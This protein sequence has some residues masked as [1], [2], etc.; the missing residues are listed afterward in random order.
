[1]LFSIRLFYTSVS[2]LLS[3]TQGY[4]YHLS[5]KHFESRKLFTSILTLVHTCQGLGRDLSLLSSHAFIWY[6]SLYLQMQLISSWK[7]PYK[8]ELTKNFTIKDSEIQ[9]SNPFQD[10]MRY[11]IFQRGQAKLC[12]S[13]NLQTPGT[14]SNEKVS[15][16][17]YVLNKGQ[18]SA[19]IL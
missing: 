15:C 1:M 3:C 4:C 9:R 12:C 14:E 11:S 5:K 17:F 8:I 6:P 10:L 18:Y 7:S 16:S 13:N 2:L 19:L